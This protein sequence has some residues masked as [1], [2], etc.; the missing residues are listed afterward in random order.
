MQHG[1]STRLLRP[2]VEKGMQTCIYRSGGTE[3]YEWTIHASSVHMHKADMPTCWN[4]EDTLS[5]RVT[6]MTCKAHFSAHQGLLDW[7]HST[8]IVWLEGPRALSLSL[9]HV[10]S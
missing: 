4:I 9:M 1:G 2:L 10:F 5:S 7:G 6:S 8:T 3:F